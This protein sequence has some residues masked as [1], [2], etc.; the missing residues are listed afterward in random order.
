MTHPILN[1]WSLRDNL[2]ETPTRLMGKAH[3]FPVDFPLNQSNE[4]KDI[5][6]FPMPPPFP[7]LFSRS[8]G[9]EP[10]RGHGA[11][12]ERL[13]QTLIFSDGCNL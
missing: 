13:R 7:S 3:G 9:G 1:H 11:R 6:G 4:S 2:Q 10:T 5:P 8:G 12:C